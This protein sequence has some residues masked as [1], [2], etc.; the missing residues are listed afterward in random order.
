MFLLEVLLFHGKFGACDQPKAEAHF[1]IDAR[2]FSRNPMNLKSSDYDP[3]SNKT[4]GFGF[5][6]S[7]KIRLLMVF[8]Y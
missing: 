4:I 1:T 5:R 8:L 3:Q 7:H 6:A 2:E